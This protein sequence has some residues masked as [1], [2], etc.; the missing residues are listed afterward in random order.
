MRFEW[1]EDKARR[2]VRDHGVSFRE[3]S[4]AFDDPHAIR[5]DDTTQHIPSMNLVNG[6]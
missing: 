5:G 1:D 3:A 4:L 2:N 6:F